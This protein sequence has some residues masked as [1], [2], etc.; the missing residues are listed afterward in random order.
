M[1]SHPLDSLADGNAA[2]GGS[3]DA[4]LVVGF[5]PA[6]DPS[7]AS[8][9][10]PGGDGGGIDRHVRSTERP[11]SVDVD[12]AAGGVLDVSGELVS[13]ACGSGR[14]AS[15]GQADHGATS[16][17]G[18]PADGGGE[19]RPRIGGKSSKVGRGSLEDE[20]S[21]RDRAGQ[22]FSLAG[23]GTWSDRDSHRLASGTDGELVRAS[24]A[25]RRV[26]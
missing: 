10:N 16:H 7:L 21:S 13:G 5:V 22:A 17:G 15:P 3:G 6:I 19:H 26:P 11:I 14:I 18:D 20:H 1:G 12:L 4:L 8:R 2:R 23:V 9:C 25:N 24:A